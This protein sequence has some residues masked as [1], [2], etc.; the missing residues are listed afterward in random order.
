[1]TSSISIY[2]IHVTFR[3]PL[4]FA[5]AWCTDYTPADR[6]LEGDPGSRQILRKGRRPRFT[7]T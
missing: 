7:R 5:Y 1:M 4:A 2:E 6:K 3:A